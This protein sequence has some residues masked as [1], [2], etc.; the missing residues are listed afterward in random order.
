M[1]EP[2]L[3]RNRPAEQ[4]EIF[5]DPLR[6][7]QLYERI[8]ERLEVEIRSGNLPEGACLPSE[9]RLAHQLEVSRS[10]VREAVAELAT[11]GVVTTR[12]GS[13]SFV[14]ADALQRLPAA[15]APPPARD[16]SPS[17]ALEARLCIEPEVARL[18]AR[19]AAPDAEAERLIGLMD[20]ACE[21]GNPSA[22][23]NWSEADRRFHLQLARMTL[24]P[25]LVELCERIALL[26]DEPLW[27]RLRDESVVQPEHR[28]VH[29]AEHRMIYEAVV[30]GDADT[31]AFY[32]A[33]HIERVR[34]YMNL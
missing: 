15:D 20:Q 2:I 12:P 17:A 33:R 28:T 32:A 4:A 7:P 3:T 6:P 26:M 9:R 5:L 25:V 18:A 31:A 10:S 19:R 8:V 29:R 13:G 11:R 34:R 14:A 24:N 27:R 21:P 22:V 1:S 16:A 23:S 30:Q